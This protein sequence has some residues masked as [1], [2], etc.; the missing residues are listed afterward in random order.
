MSAN[1]GN[2]R[3]IEELERNGEPNSEQAQLQR[4]KYNQENRF[5]EFRPYEVNHQQNILQNQNN[6]LKDYEY[7]K[8][9]QEAEDNNTNP[10]IASD[11]NRQNSFPQSNINQ[12]PVYQPTIPAPQPPRPQFNPLEPH[13]Q[14]NPYQNPINQP[15]INNPQQND[16]YHPY[17]PDQEINENSNKI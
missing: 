10:P 8:A 2:M 14:P 7:A 3:Y 6:I 13:Q 11:I 5:P 15:I 16:S 1:Q 4:Q 12:N 9:L 17:Y